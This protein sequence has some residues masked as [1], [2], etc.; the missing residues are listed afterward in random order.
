M[1]YNIL[2]AVNHGS[3]CS[4]CG[5]NNI[6]MDNESGEIYCTNCGYVIT[7]RVL[8]SGP[9]WRSFSQDERGNRART[10]APTSLS[11]HDMGLSTVI[12]PVNRDSTGRPLASSMRS[13]IERLR[14]WDNRSQVHEPMDRNFRQ[15]FSELNRLKDK[16]SLSDAV[17]ENA[18]YIYRKALDKGLVRGRSISALMA[19]ALF[20]AC[21]DTGTARNIKDVEEASNI[22]K[23]DIARCYRLLV[24]ELDLRMPVPDPIL[25]VSRIASHLSI[26]EKTKRYAIM[27]LKEAQKMEVSAGKDPMGLAA[28]ALYLACV[29]CGDNQ[30]QR[31]IANA[32]HVTEVTIRNRYKGLRDSI[33]LEDSHE[34]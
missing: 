24:K 31:N 5:R 26:E 4:R 14:T 11:M 17:V 19:A 2:A 30:T 25:C 16:M 22:K 23:K 20:V 29:K 33:E 9:E 12:N 27:A 13:T 34:I 7:E 21:R 28:A 8:E 32:A 10:G 6:V 18:A 15:A 1:L 3:A